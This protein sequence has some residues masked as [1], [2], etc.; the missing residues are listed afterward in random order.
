MMFRLL[1]GGCERLDPPFQIGLTEAKMFPDSEV[2]NR[3][4]LPSASSLAGLLVE[5]TRLELQE[6]GGFFEGEDH[7][8]TSTVL[9]YHSPLFLPVSR[10]AILPSTIASRIR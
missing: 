6:F 3:V 7:G 2:R 8:F 5:L 9:R 10:V 1:P 4:F